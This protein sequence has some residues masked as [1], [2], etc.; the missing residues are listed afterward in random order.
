MSLLKEEK[1]LFDKERDDYIKLIRRHLQQLKLLSH[2]VQL[3]VAKL[4]Q[5]KDVSGEDTLLLQTL[6]EK[7]Q[8]GI[9]KFKGKMKKDFENTMSEERDLS[10]EVMIMNERFLNLKNNIQDDSDDSDDDYIPR[11]RKATKH[12]VGRKNGSGDIRSEI[13]A[14]DREI[15]E[16]GGMLGGWHSQEHDFFLAVWTQVFGAN[17]VPPDLRSPSFRRSVGQL[18]EKALVG[19]PSRTSDEVEG[20]ALWYCAHLRK[21]GE[22]KQAIEKWRQMKESD[23]QSVLELQDSQ[24]HVCGKDSNYSRQPT[25]AQMEEASR[26]SEEKRRALGE[27]KARKAQEILL[28]EEQAKQVEAAEVQKAMKLKVAQRQKQEAVALY[29]LEKEQRALQEEQMKAVLENSDVGQKLSDAELRERR[30][31]DVVKAKEKR[32]LIAKKNK[33]N[34][35]HLLEQKGRRRKEELRDR[36]PRDPSRAT[37]N[38]QNSLHK[39]VSPEELDGEYDRRSHTAAHGARVAM[40]AYDLKWGGSRAVPSWRKG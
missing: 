2:K 30:A 40:G 22:K 4:S 13:Q 9:A 15:E 16:T 38:T 8:N 29:R 26:V 33:A 20:H 21:L 14:I 24:E 1:T 19:V 7:L 37:K 31:L 27:W 34:R 18:R 10:R 32:D 17:A 3:L 36:T 39:K 11:V 23:H 6:M 35:A 12:P 25:S 5:G 28:A